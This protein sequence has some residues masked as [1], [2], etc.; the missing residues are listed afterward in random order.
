MRSSV[1]EGAEEPVQGSIERGL[2]N[3]VYGKNNPLF[4]VKNEAA[5]FTPAA[6]AEFLAR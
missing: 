6:A 2:Q 3:V 5:V 1:E 4:S